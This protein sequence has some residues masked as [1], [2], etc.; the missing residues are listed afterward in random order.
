MQH[1]RSQHFLWSAL[2]FLE[3]VDDLLLV[4]AIKTQAQTT[5]LTA[6]TLQIFPTHQNV[7]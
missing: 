5:K 4:T 7:I 3:K 6:P 1:R 2:V